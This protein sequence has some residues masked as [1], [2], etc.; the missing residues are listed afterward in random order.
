MLPKLPFLFLT[1][2]IACF[3]CRTEVEKDCSNNPCGTPGCETECCA[4]NPC[5]NPDKCPDE[6]PDAPLDLGLTDVIVS[7]EEFETMIDQQTGARTITGSGLIQIDADCDVLELRLQNATIR[8]GPDGIFQ[9]LSGEYEESAE[10]C[11]FLP[12]P[13]AASRSKVQMD[14]F[15]QT[16]Q[17]IEDYDLAFAV[18]PSKKYFTFALRWDADYGICVPD[19]T[20]G[21]RILE[22]P[23]FPFTLAQSVLL[24]D[25]CDPM[26][27]FDI[28]SDF[29]GGFAMG[30]SL[31]GAFRYKPTH[32]IA[33]EIEEFDGKSLRYGEFTFKDF[34]N[35]EG[36]II[37]ARTFDVDLA[38]SNF[39]DS[40]FG[41]GT[42][43]GFNGAGS[44]DLMLFKIPFVAGSVSFQ[45]VVDTRGSYVRAFLNIKG[46]KFGLWWPEYIPIK[47]TRSR[48]YTGFII[49][50]QDS[51]ELR[52]VDTY[53]LFIRVNGEE[54]EYTIA[55][56]KLITNRLASVAGTVTANDFVWETRATISADQTEITTELPLPFLENWTE[57]VCERGNSL[58]QIASDYYLDQFLPDSLEYDLALNLQDL[59]SQLPIITKKA[60]ETMNT[61]KANVVSKVCR[62]FNACTSRAC[63]TKC[64]DVVG[65]Y[66]NGVLKP[67]RDDLAALDRAV[68]GNLGAAAA[69]AQLKAALGNL[70]N[71]KTITIPEKKLSFCQKPALVCVKL[72]GTVPE[73]DITVF[74]DGVLQTLQ[75]AFDNVDKIPA[76]Q[77]P[78]LDSQLI[79][80]QLREQGAPAQNTCNG[81]RAGTTEDP[82]VSRF[83]YVLDHTT[84][85]PTYFYENKA[86]VRVETSAFSPFSISSFLKL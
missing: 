53:G 46:D 24:F 5:A 48:E 60:R 30:E 79:L 59:R 16:G 3:S 12:L 20:N 22:Q 56:E 27:Y 73:T 86:G 44:L 81:L 58:A 4:E 69:R 28:R 38:S 23:R 52:Q 8:F 83:G 13:I 51:V 17:A 54:Q 11:N 47:P 65:N 43:Y 35:L 71:K 14:L 19:A 76:A 7:E 70:L 78:Y 41:A 62:E 9:S 42:F 36:T 74:E 84:L 18:D 15:W 37:R 50:D 67:F 49:S 34:F 45:G 85:V 57:A 39:L 10:D 75:A 64:S 63:G 32:P 26:A 72:S 2:A 40:E 1:L 25:P 61:V 82:Q 66:I 77:G 6:C 31:Q 68:E 55:G 80:D 29:I 33:G 21:T